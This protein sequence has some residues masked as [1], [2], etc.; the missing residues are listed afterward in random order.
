MK[1]HYEPGTGLEKN[2]D[3]I[4]ELIEVKS[5]DTTFGLGFR[6]TQKDIKV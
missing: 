5:Q 2:K 4:L 3:E 1:R 6:P